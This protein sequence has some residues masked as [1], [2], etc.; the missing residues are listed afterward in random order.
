MTS[1]RY[2]D[3]LAQAAGS[4]EQGRRELDR[5]LDDRASAYALIAD[6]HAVL[7]ALEAHV[8][9]VVTPG[10]AAAV[11][12]AFHPDESE[13][14]AMRLVDALTKVVG[15]ERPHSSL[16]TLPRSPWARAAR[17]IRAATDLLA[18]HHDAS[19]IPRTPVAALLQSARFRDAALRRVAALTIT[20]TSVD[21]V[22]ALRVGRPES[23]GRPSVCACRTSGT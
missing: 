2:S 16:L 12:S 21:D 17:A 18:V 10:R 4:L 3:L 7:S 6:R 5:R 20:T 11:R 13:A 9:A 22:V 1:P 15:T 19:G 8:W 23:R 14:A